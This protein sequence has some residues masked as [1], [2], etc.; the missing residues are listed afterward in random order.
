[1]QSKKLVEERVIATKWMKAITTHLNLT[2]N[3]AV[4]P[5]VIERR[6]EP[7]WRHKQTNRE[8]VAC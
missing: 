2:E 7:K 3:L 4:R 8:V 1:M 6:Q 5:T